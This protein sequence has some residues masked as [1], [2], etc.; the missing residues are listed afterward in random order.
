MEKDAQSLNCGSYS[1][2]LNPQ[3]V[4][5]KRTGASDQK[6]ALKLS[7]G[8]DD[9]NGNQDGTEETPHVGGAHAAGRDILLSIQDRGGRLMP[10]DRQGFYYHLPSPVAVDI[11]G[12]LAKMVLPPAKTYNSFVHINLW[13]PLL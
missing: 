13:P 12:T 6:L 8:S 4:D 10:P 7:G 5:N 3:E 2:E 1:L 11:G 9:G